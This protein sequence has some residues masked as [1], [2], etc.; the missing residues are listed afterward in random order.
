M[1]KKLT[2]TLAAGLLAFSLIGS[3]V[4]APKNAAERYVDDAT[5]TATIK[6]KQAEDKV[7]HAT[8]IGVETVNG[9]VQLS[10]FTKSDA[11]KQRAETLAKSVDG[12]KSVKN[13]IIVKK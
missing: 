11:E 7:V 5:I 9:V 2:S 8:A 3:A 4:A 10:G 6:A 12:V 1:N 13:D